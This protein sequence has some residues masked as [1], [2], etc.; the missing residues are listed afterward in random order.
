[1]CAFV[2]RRLLA[3]SLVMLFAAR[4]RPRPVD[5]SAG[6]GGRGPSGA[7]AR[8]LLV[9]VIPGRLDEAVADGLLAEA[10]GNPSALLEL[11]RGLSAAQLA[12]GFG[13][14]GA[15]SL[16]GRFE[17]SFLDRFEA[18]PAEAQRL[19]L[20]AAAEPSVTARFGRAAERLGI[21]GAMLEPAESAGLVK[22]EGRVR[23]H[24]PLVQVGDL[25]G[26]H[27]DD[28]RLVPPGAGRREQSAR[29]DFPTTA[30]T[31]RRRSPS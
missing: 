12:G 15:L 25:P 14:P 20:A 7:D 26:G 1:M 3:E 11:P 29:V 6:A 13:L 30:L 9:S 31:W 10:R 17:E 8:S 23:F 21:A 24:H 16:S 5:G 28:Q 19:L 27:A 18:L 4:V 22:I 2:A